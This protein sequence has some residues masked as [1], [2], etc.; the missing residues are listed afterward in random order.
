MPIF[1]VESSTSANSIIVIIHYTR[2]IRFARSLFFYARTWIYL[3][4]ITIAFIDSLTAFKIVKHFYILLKNAALSSLK[5]LHG[6][7]TV[8][9]VTPSNNN[10]CA[11]W[12]LQYDVKWQ[13]L[14]LNF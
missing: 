5:Q 7:S 9:Y 4:L 11:P 1:S 6:L 2:S 12:H 3:K 13:S 14:L 10:N 8:A